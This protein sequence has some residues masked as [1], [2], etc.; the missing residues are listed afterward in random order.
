MTQPKR[1]IVSEVPSNMLIGSY[2]EKVY[3]CHDRNYPNIPVF[4][5]IGNKKKA[6][7]MCRMMNST[8]G[9]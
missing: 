2:Y 3:Y 1:Y 8:C 5:S 7:K 6:N 4:G 9:R